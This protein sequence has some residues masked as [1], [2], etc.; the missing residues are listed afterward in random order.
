MQK[1][2]QDVLRGDYARLQSGTVGYGKYSNKGIRA[3][4]YDI[5]KVD[6]LMTQSGWKR[7]ADG[8][9]EKGEL[10]FSV[11]LLFG[12]KDYTEWLVVLKEEAK[13]AGLELNLQLLDGSTFLKMASENRHEVAL[14]GLGGGLRPQ[15]WGSYHS[16][17]AHKPQSNNLTNTDDPELDKLIDRYRESTD[18]EERIQL[19]KEIQVKIHEI[20]AFV[21]TFTRDYFRVA[22]WRWWQFPEVPATRLSDGL[23]DSFGT[24]LY[25]FDPDVKK[26]TMEAMQSGKTFKAETITDTTFKVN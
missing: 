10:R 1:L 6:Q 5:G 9:W 2:L 26:E 20:G 22:Y 23:F 21:P 25:W 17:N 8:I 11:K 15:F 24:G 3:R 7:G 16:T 12:Y 4:T 13:K 14:M 19:A 18:E